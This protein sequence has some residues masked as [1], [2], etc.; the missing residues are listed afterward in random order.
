[1]QVESNWLNAEGDPGRPWFRHTLYPARF[2]YAH[3]ERS[4]LTEAVEKGDWGVEKQQVQVLRTP[5]Q[6]H[7]ATSRPRASSLNPTIAPRDDA[8]LR[9]DFA[10]FATT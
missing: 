4:G 1:M 9:C 6:R 8:T 7:R 5:L 2:T 10:A 3:L